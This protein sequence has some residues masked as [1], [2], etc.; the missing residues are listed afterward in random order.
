MARLRWLVGLVAA[1][2]AISLA[3]SP[4]ASGTPGGAQQATAQ[5]RRVAAKDA[6]QRLARLGL[7]AGA[8]VHV[9]PVV[10]ARS[11]LP[12]LVATTANADAAE[13]WWVP[14]TINSVFGYIRAHPPAGS[15]QS[16]WG[17]DGYPGH[18]GYD[19]S[20]TFTWPAIGQVLDNR[21]LYVSITSLGSDRAEVYAQ[22][23]SIW[24]VAR[25]TG[26][27]I[28]A[29]T[30]SIDVSVQHGHRT[31]RSLTVTRRAEVIRIVS[32]FNAMEIV[33]PATYNCPAIAP[34]EQRHISFTFA[35]ARAR[36]LAHLSYVES[37][38]P[39]EHGSGP[40]NPVALTIDRRSQRPLLGNPQLIRVQK[41]IG[42]NGAL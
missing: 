7:P 9:S 23:E 14:G 41:M 22:A 33:Q 24:V 37:T 31:L 1:L 35:D 27:R 39:L 11:H 3:E 40:C 36:P 13:V 38:I 25:P 18:R 2:G 30:R 21:M 16:G 20:L 15:T 26:E 8:I 19:K 6:S 28:P 29:T 5:H 17:Y 34:N 10:E 42:I 12:A 4:F 32:L